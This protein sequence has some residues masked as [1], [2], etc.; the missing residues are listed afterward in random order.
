[1]RITWITD[2]TSV[3]SI[4]EYGTSPGVYNSSSQGDSDSYSYFLYGSGKI[5]HV[6][7]GP[8]ESNKIYFYRC[9][10]YG[11]DYSFKTPPAQFSIVFAIVGEISAPCLA[12]MQ[13]FSNLLY[14]A[15]SW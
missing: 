13:A 14:G 1:M 10:G 2:D 3:P 11:P 9:G 15:Y 6:V 8:L 5:H 7:I 4:V 12:H